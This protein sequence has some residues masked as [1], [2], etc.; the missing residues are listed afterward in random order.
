M[1]KFKQTTQFK[2]DFKKYEHNKK[3]LVSFMNVL[4]QLREEGKVEAKYNP[5]ML[6]GDYQ[7]CMECHVE[8]D[9][10]LIWIDEE[11]QT[12]RLTRLGSHSELFGK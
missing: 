1:W 7:G 4:S 2:K 8:N 12:I 11:N 9:F 10:L 6:K 5:H 3:K